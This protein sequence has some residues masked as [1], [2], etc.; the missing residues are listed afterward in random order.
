MP[1]IFAPSNSAPVSRQGR[2]S[3]KDESLKSTPASQ[4]PSLMHQ[5]REPRVYKSPKDLRIGSKGDEPNGDQ[6]LSVGAW[7]GKRKDCRFTTPNTPAI[8]GWGWFPL[9]HRLSK[10][11]LQ[12]VRCSLPAVTNL[13]LL[14][15]AVY[16]VFD[17]LKFQIQVDTDF[18]IAHAIPDELKHFQ[19]SL[20]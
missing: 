9:R 16:V 5:G 2:I 20:R 14:K 4:Y 8:R 1:T 7:V 18:F 12:R 3:G 19:F 13:K 6:Y 17:R 11:T 10:W 15:K